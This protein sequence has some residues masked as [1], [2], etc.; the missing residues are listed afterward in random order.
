MSTEA[1]KESDMNERTKDVKRTQAERRQETRGALLAAACHLF[2]QQGFESTSLEEIADECGLTIRPIYYHFGSKLGL[3]AAVNALME[4][5][6]REAL[7]S[8]SSVLAWESFL[9]LCEDKAFRKIVLEEAPNVLGRERWPASQTFPWS[10]ALAANLPGSETA[11]DSQAEMCGRVAR[12]ALTEAA[13][14]VLDS[15]N[16]MGARSEAIELISRLLPEAP[17]SEHRLYTQQTIL[18]R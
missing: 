5:Q 4:Q 3:F 13:I 8:G 18:N 14:A 11:G 6:A 9:A 1:V 17:A 15:G 7:C 12:A 10:G 16:D 2:G